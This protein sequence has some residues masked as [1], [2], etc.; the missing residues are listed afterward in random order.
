MKAI[1]QQ[2]VLNTILS[3]L[4][5]GLGFLNM[6]ILFPQILST[7]QIGLYSMLGASANL[8]ASISRLGTDSMIIRYFAFFRKDRAGQG[9]FTA[10]LALLTSAGFLLFVLLFLLFKPLIVDF[11][12]SGS[13]LYNEY[14]HLVI[15]LVL[16]MLLFD[17]TF[18]YGRSV[19]K[20][21]LP[22]FL[23][24]VLLRIYTL[25]MIMGLYF[26]LYDFNTFVWLYVLSYVVPFVVMGSS[27]IKA[28][29]FTFNTQLSLIGNKR[30]MVV[31]GG[32]MLIGTL[33]LVLLLDIDKLM[34]AGLLDLDATGIYGITAFFGTVIMVPARAV[35]MIASPI[36]A[37]HI[38]DGSIDKIKGIYQ[39][40]ALNQL[41]VGL[42]L[43]IG[44]YINIDNVLQIL[45]P[46]YEAGKYVILLLGLARLIDMSMGMNGEIIANSPFFKFDLLFNIILMGL[47]IGTNAVFIPW[48]GISGAAFATL[49]S[50]TTFTLLRFLLIWSKYRIQPFSLST[51]KVLLAGLLLIGINYLIP[52]LD[53]WVADLVLRSVV[54]TVVYLAVVL[55]LRLSPDI[56]D[57]VD[58]LIKKYRSRK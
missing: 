53:F 14:S 47:C 45:P 10:L 13:P 15:P 7:E 19:Y 30:E 27:L 56:S 49:I 5:I 51:I 40:S 26:G 16:F 21:V 31:Y 39:K 23:K 12:S 18:H 32:Y 28:G 8:A 2:S 1:Q 20:T 11:Y 42:L 4:G 9:A 48:M 58:G 46:E 25:G 24:E 35:V 38:K 22:T 52:T 37:D 43:Y 41:I 29:D 55:G 17:L 44:V 3:Y 54:V 57:L 6:A 50:L 36:V 34:I 33:S